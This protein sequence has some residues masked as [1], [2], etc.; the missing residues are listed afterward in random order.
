MAK[1]RRSPAKKPK[2]AYRP[3]SKKTANTNR[4]YKASVFSSLFSEY[5]DELPKVVP[6]S[7]PPDTAIKDVTLDD[8]L[9][10]DQITGS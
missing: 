3:N 1:K 2:S 7:I 6:V 10:M 9:F 5:L 4:T 8:A